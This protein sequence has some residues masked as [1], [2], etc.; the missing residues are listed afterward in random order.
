MVPGLPTMT[1]AALQMVQ[2]VSMGEGDGEGCWSKCPGVCHNW[3]AEQAPRSPVTHDGSVPNCP[4]GSAPC[5]DTSP[6]A[7]GGS[8]AYGV[9][10]LTFDST[11]AGAV[12]YLKDLVM[13]SSGTK[14]AVGSGSADAMA[15]A[16]YASKYY[17]GSSTVPSV[18]IDGYAKGI[19][20]RAKALAACMGEPLLVTR[21]PLGGTDPIL[22]G[23]FLAS[24]GALCWGAWDWY[25]EKQG[26]K[27]R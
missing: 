25:K 13:R 14:S 17:Q 26:R 4:A 2:A 7:G 22:I 8:T 10:F 19:A 16:M 3:G 20:R 23:L 27:R 21:G 1:T 6:N 18:A 15:S 12:R 11:A 9:C 5:V 24:T